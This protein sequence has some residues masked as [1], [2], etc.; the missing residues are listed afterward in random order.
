MRN[1]VPVEDLLLFLRANAVVLVEEIEEGALGFFE[2]GI[3]SSLQV[4]QVGEDTLLE[5]LRVLHGASEGLEAKGQATNDIRT[6]NVK[7]VAPVRG[8]KG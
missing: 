4:S 6:G 8:R 3:G 2:G 7:E 5:L 1:A